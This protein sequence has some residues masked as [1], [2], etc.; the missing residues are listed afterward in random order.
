MIDVTRL[1]DADPMK[2]RVVVKDAGGES[3][4][5]VTMTRQTLDRLTAGRY[6]GGAEACLE[7]AFRFL[8]DHEPKEAI[9]ARFDVDVISR[10]FPAFEK[11]LP[12]YLDGTP[13]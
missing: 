10:Y 12:A 13:D 8:L 4:H 6:G 2:F 5:E 7:G 9:L 1:D 3:R 11:S